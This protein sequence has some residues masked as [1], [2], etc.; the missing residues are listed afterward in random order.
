MDL[1][2]QRYASP[3]LVLDEF[4]RVHQLHDFVTE[5]FNTISEEKIHETRW[6]FYLH[7]V[8]NS[9]SFGEY[10]QACEQQQA[11]DKGMTNQEIGNVIEESMKI[12]EGFKPE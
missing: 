3:F 12:L 7:K 1:L 6:Q 9:M 2:A 4:I 11:Q 10:V 8:F 5:I